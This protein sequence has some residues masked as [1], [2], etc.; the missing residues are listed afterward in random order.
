MELTEKQLRGIIKESVMKAL[1]ENKYDMYDSG[2]LRYRGT[3][4]KESS[5]RVR[6]IMDKS[7]PYPPAK[8]PGNIYKAGDGLYKTNKSS[9]DKAKETFGG[10]KA[11]SSDGDSFEGFMKPLNDKIDKMPYDSPN[12]RKLNDLKDMFREAYKKWTEKYRDEN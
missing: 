9:W 6:K 12:A 4:S 11:F 1:S 10:E 2:V 8:T 7:E 3:G 5:D